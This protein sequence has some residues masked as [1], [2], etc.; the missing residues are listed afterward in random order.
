MKDDTKGN[1][2]PRAA[3]CRA[4][5]RPF[6]RSPGTWPWTTALAS[7]PT[8]VNVCVHATTGACRHLSHNK[9]PNTSGTHCCACASSS[10]PQLATDTCILRA[11]T[12]CTHTL[13][14][15]CLNS[16]RVMMHISMCGS[17]YKSLENKRRTC[18]CTH[19]CVRISAYTHRRVSAFQPHLESIARI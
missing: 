2:I 9:H 14:H 12:L 19:T 13:M 17:L 4:T 11:I 15:A 1:K 5:K 10:V 8:S 7:A 18:S 16:P 3:L 6:C